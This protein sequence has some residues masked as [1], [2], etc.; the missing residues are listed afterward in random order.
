MRFTLDTKLTM[1]NL[2]YVDTMVTDNWSDMSLG[3]R[4]HDKDQRNILRKT[5]LI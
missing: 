1:H 2:H 3:A 4:I 5:I